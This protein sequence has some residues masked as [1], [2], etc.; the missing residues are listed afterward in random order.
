M[1]HFYMRS[2]EIRQR[3]EISPGRVKV[4]KKLTL[5]DITVSKNYL[6]QVFL[7]NIKFVLKITFRVEVSLVAT[8][9]DFILY[10]RRAKATIGTNLSR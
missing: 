10:H 9:H 6:R 4:L 8:H 5:I 7:P 3:T 2:Y 1:K